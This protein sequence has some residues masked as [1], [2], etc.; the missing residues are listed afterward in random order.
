MLHMQPSP[1]PWLQQALT[2]LVA[3]TDALAASRSSIAWKE[4]PS[5]ALCRVVS[6]FYSHTARTESSTWRQQ[7]LTSRVASTEA[8]AASRSSIPDSPGPQSKPEVWVAFR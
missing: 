6:P 2:L 5:A 7:A 8:F 3:S 4:L 1:Q